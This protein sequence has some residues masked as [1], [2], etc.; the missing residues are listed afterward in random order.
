MPRVIVT[1]VSHGEPERESRRV[2][3]QASEAYTRELH[4]R[5]PRD[6]RFL[7]F[8]ANTFESDQW[9]YDYGVP[10]G[11]QRLTVGPNV[12]PWYCEVE[13]LPDEADGLAAWPRADGDLRPSSADA[14][15]P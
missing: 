10:D 14:P 1:L 8:E 5:T 6:E 2:T 4:D 7:L 3:W 11:I 13:V 15:G 9:V 12:D